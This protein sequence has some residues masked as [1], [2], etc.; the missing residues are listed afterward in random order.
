SDTRPSS[1]IAILH[2]IGQCGPL[3]G[4]NLFPNSEGP[5]YARAMWISAAF[6][7][8]T[9]VLALGL[10]FLLIWENKKLDLKYGVKSEIPLRNGIDPASMQSAV[11]EENYGPNFRF[12][13]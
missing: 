9:A 3:L 13:L 12:V 11:R 2:L 4:T 7:L 10:R 8:F 6:T 1:G 5:R